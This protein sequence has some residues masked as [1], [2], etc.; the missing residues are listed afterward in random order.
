MGDFASIDAEK[1]LLLRPDLVIGIA[2]QARMTASL[3][4]LHLRVALFKDLSYD[5]LFADIRDVGA[6]TGRTPAAGALIAR[7]R[8]RTAALQ[9]QTRAFKRRPT[10]F[11]LLGTDPIF[12]AGA[13]SYIATLVAIAG[14]RNAVGSLPGGYAQYGAEALLRLQP[15]AIVTDPSMHVSD[16]LN[17]E[18]W[19]SLRAVRA[20]RV[21]TLPD[22]AI[23]E[24]PGPRY[25]EGI[26]WL[27]EHLRTIAT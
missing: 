14:G 9:R 10:V 22:P 18:P 19:R 7:L 4:D 24:R 17:R 1:V 11:V 5:D 23:L 21:W 6:L 2:S 27:V 20:G 25:D 16:V 3:A 26:A 13:N 8:A 12:T 15:D